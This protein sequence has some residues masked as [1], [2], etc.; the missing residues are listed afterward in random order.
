MMQFNM[1]VQAKDR[2]RMLTKSRLMRNYDQTSSIFRLSDKFTVN[3]SVRVQC[4]LDLAVH[5]YI[6]MDCMLPVLAGEMQYNGV[7]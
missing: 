3:L 2:M 6:T 7:L 1:E 5:R 4:R